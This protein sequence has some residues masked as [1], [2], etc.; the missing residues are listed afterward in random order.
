MSLDLRLKMQHVEVTDIMLKF[1]APVG[2]P[3][4]NTKIWLGLNA[5]IKEF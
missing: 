4:N 5:V 3:V 1:A 2:T